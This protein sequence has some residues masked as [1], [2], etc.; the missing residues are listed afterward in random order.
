MRVLWQYFPA[1]DR[2]EESWFLAKRWGVA[3]NTEVAINTEFTV[4]LN[5]DMLVL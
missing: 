2:T 1:T 3:L 4:E 5:R